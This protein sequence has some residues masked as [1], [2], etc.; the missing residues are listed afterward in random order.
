LRGAQGGVVPLRGAQGGVVPL[1][2]AQGGVQTSSGGLLA[3]EK[4]K[5]KKIKFGD[6][7]IIF[8]QLKGELPNQISEITGSPINHCGLIVVKGNDI[9]VLEAAAK[10]VLTPIETWTRRGNDRKFALLRA[11]TQDDKTAENVVKCGDKFLGRPY[12]FEYRL[13]DENIYCSELVY[14]AYKKGAG[15]KVGNL[16]PL[17][18]LNYKGHEEFIRKLTGELPL[19]REIITPVE[20]YKS[21]YFTKIYD[22]FDDESP[23]AKKNE[24]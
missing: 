19:E 16:T 9:F 15:I 13:D 23:E 20:L 1:R 14:K 5:S 11:K 21:K 18:R 8:Q 17:E 22:D 3:V 12:D 10:V 4:N 2:G 24:Q 7:D 6:G